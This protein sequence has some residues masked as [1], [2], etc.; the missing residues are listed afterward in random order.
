MLLRLSM[1][2][3]AAALAAM[4]GKA[5]AARAPTDK[6]VVNFAAAQC[7]AHRDYGTP[8][9]PL[10][11]V[12]KAPP[13]GK[14]MQIA[15]F[16]KGDMARGAQVDA[17]VKVDGGNPLKASVLMY[18]PKGGNEVVYLFNMPISEFARVRAGKELTIRSRQLDETLAL[19]QMEPLL[20]V[21]DE[22]TA[23]LRQ[24]WNVGDEEGAAPSGVA[25]RAAANL[26]SYFSS[27]DYP[28]AA[29]WSG[30]TGTVRFAVLVGENGRVA[31]C[32][33][34]ETSGVAVLDVQACAVLRERARFKPALG[35]DG[36]PTK[37]AQI[38]SI[39]WA[40]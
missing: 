11:L 12:L 8:E 17:T 7:V 28:S 29:L 21:M 20:K 14:V 13:L 32:T 19:A 40:L 9:D 26:A 36:K 16:R 39:R 27:D 4:A 25:S 10:R 35:P 30:Q 24:V 5:E 33:V 23:D 22:C 1:L 15:I 31:D 3:L 34:I 38:C 2:C 18:T 6:W 37:D